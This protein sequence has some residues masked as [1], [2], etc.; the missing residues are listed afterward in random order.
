MKFGGTS[1]CDGNKI[2]HVADLVAKYYFQNNEI[3]VVASAMSEVTDKLIEAAEKAKKGNAAYLEEFIQQLRKRHVE[4]A[5]TSIG[6]PKIAESTVKEIEE[7]VL[8]L[9]K[10]LAG[11]SYLGELTPRSRDYVLS[12][13]EKLCVP[14]LCGALLDKRVRA[15]LFTGENVGIIT[16][17]NFGR[18]EPLLNLTYLQVKKKLE[19]LLQAKIVP[20]VTGFFGV[21][22]NGVVT[23]LGR[24]GSDYTATILG[25]A[26]DVDE[27]WIWTDVDGLMTAD[28]KIEPSARTISELSFEEALE[29][30]YFG[31]KVT[32]P[33]VLKPAIQ[34]H[35]PIRIRNTFNPE[36]NGTI[37]RKGQKI[38]SKNI[39]K[40]V[41]IVKSVSLMTAGGAGIAGP[42]QVAATVFQALENN[43]IDVLMTSQSSSE[44]NISF[45]IPRK[46]SEKVLSV[47]EI[48]PRRNIVR[49]LTFEDDVC[50]IAVVGAGMKGTPGVAARVFQA[51]AREGIN[52]RMI[53]Q[54][55]SELS[56]SFVVKE[57][58]G[59]RAVR[60]LHRE[61][62]LDKG[63]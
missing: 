37:I 21:T 47:L 25:A 59:D 14:I 3:V 15:Q 53:A 60:A 30:A 38:K 31:A 2:K 63:D 6:D 20:V 55:S 42:S 22:Q 54:G 45:I 35:I 58:D 52:I 12:F 57:G 10:V 46:D 48:V 9:E 44:A 51:V 16:D 40:A 4:A 39:V 61:F 7:E 56:I 27:V 11:I 34:K 41:S 29:M 18:A 49:E 36:N 1:L 5:R 19:P 13:G 32:R 62:E 28:P 8:K 23:T 33:H 50:V 24:G 43:D 26:L 17:E